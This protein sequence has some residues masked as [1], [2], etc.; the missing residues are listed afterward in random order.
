MDDIEIMNSACNSKLSAYKR[1]RN[2]LSEPH[3]IPVKWDIIRN[4][5]WSPLK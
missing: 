4:Q 5:I 3:W 1:I 2:A